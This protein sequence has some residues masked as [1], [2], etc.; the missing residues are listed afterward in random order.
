MN[1]YTCSIHELTYDDADYPPSIER[2]FCPACVAAASD[3]EWPLQRAYDAEWSLWNAWRGNSD[4]PERYRNRTLSNWTARGRA[5][6]AAQ[7]AVAAYAGAILTHADTGAGLTLLGP[8]GVG[9]SHLCCGVIAAAYQAGVHARYAVWSD[10]VDRTKAT[11]GTRDSEDRTLVDDLKRVPLLV[12]D[13]LGVRQGTEWDQALLFGL[14]DSRY[15]RSM[16]TVVASNLTADALNTI[17]ERAADRLRESNVTVSIPGESQRTAAATNREL[18]DAPP[19]LI[20]P[21]PPVVTFPVCVNGELVQRPLYIKRQTE[22]H[23]Y[24]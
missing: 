7:K 3:A 18:I 9:K 2:I 19:A 21:E 8:P 13:E 15:R 5:Q 16:P 24:L 11:F 22:R 17:G 20:E 23:R 10:V 12:L 1:T 14:I 6:Q 4:V